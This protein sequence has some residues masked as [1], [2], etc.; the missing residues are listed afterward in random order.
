M[1]FERRRTGVELMGES[2]V[3]TVKEHYWLH[4]GQARLSMMCGSDEEVIHAMEWSSEVVTRTDVEPPVLSGPLDTRG[5]DVNW[6]LKACA[7]PFAIDR[8]AGTCRTP[9][10]NDNIAAAL[11]SLHQL[12]EFAQTVLAQLQLPSGELLSALDVAPPVLPLLELTDAQWDEVQI[13]Y[14]RAFSA[15][16]HRLPSPLHRAIFA[17]R[18]VSAMIELYD[19]GVDHVED[20]LREQLVGVLGREISSGDFAEYARFHLGTTLKELYQASLF[21]HS[22]RRDA[23]HDAEAI[24]EVCICI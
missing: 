23:A 22:L 24:L 9:R 6:L 11:D 10:R 12:R 1:D 20:V 3:T 5:C 17:L 4:S 7:A 18:H 14:E 13:Q 8:S 21:S 19:L 16:M 2:I 15:T